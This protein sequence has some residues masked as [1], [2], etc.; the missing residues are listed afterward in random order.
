MGRGRLGLQ[1]GPELRDPTSN[2]DWLS[3][4]PSVVLSFP[5]IKVAIIIM[6]IMLTLTTPEGYGEAPG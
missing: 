6:T 4:V 1:A 2:T 3:P 5:V